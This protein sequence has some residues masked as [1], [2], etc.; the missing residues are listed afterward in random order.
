MGHDKID[1]GPLVGTSTI[2]VGRNEALTIA[3]ARPKVLRGEGHD[4]RR[5]T[6]AWSGSELRTI[7]R[8]RGLRM[9]RG[10]PTLAVPSRRDIVISG[11][12]GMASYLT[13]GTIVTAQRDATPSIEAGSFQFT[14]I[15][16][17]REVPSVT[18]FRL[19]GGATNLSSL[20]GKPILLNFWASWCAACRPELS[21]F[22]RQLRGVWRDR[23]HVAAV[24]T[25]RDGRQTVERFVKAQDLRSVPVYLDPNGYV[26][27]FDDENRK[28]APFILYGMPITYLIAS[29]GLMVG[30]IQ[31]APDWS[32]AAANDLIEHL[33]N[34]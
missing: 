20:R 29:S 2:Q 4:L 8:E 19:Q 18:L 7:S 14:I 9:A 15:K 23:L 26:G 22:E 11:S 34:T 24:S 30:Y 3:S 32:S 33:R 16:P 28:N 12:I 6:V 25:D 1:N 27:A 10:R 13:S 5:R 31:G 17:Q 21:F